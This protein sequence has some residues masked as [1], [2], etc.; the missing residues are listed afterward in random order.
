MPLAGPESRVTM[1]EITGG[2]D[3]GVASRSGY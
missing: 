3:P 2:A 1:G